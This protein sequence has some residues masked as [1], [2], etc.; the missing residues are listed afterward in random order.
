MRDTKQRKERL[1][2]M[3]PHSVVET[4]SRIIWCD[5]SIWMNGWLK[6]HFR[7]WWNVRDFHFVKI[8]MGKKKEIQQ[9]ISGLMEVFLCVKIISIQYLITFEIHHVNNLCPCYS[10]LICKWPDISSFLIE[11][12]LFDNLS[13]LCTKNSHSKWK[14]Y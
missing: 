3:K 4:N 5:V 6:I 14:Y 1:M 7:L 2:I 10:H 9:T 13:Q 8:L 11:N 12:T